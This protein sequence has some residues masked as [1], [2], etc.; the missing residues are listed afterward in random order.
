MKMNT[1]QHPFENISLNPHGNLEV[2][3]FN[4]SSKVVKLWPLLIRCVDTG[5]VS[6][7]M[8]ESMQSKSV[9]SSLI[10]LQFRMGRIKKVSIDAGSNLIEL[11][12]MAENSNGLLQF[13]EAVVHPISSQYRNYCERAV[14]MVKKVAWMRRRKQKNKKTPCVNERRSGPYYG[15]GLLLY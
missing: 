1:F 14:Q 7:L 15:V 10:R 2:R 12:R 13:E 5:S 9:V 6:C 4:N 8:I 11:K 3:A